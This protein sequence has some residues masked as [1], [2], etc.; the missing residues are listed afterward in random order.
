LSWEDKAIV[1]TLV[2]FNWSHAVDEYIYYL[3]S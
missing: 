2:P 1:C 3:Q